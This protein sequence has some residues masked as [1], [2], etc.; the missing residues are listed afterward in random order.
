MNFTAPQNLRWSSAHLRLRASRSMIFSRAATRENNLKLQWPFAVQLKRFQLIY[1]SKNFNFKGTFRAKLHFRCPSLEAYLLANLQINYGPVSGRRFTLTVCCLKSC[2][3][4]PRSV[5]MKAPWTIVRISLG[6]V[7]L[8]EPIWSWNVEL[9]WQEQTTIRESV[10]SIMGE[11]PHKP[12]SE[13]DWR[14][15]WVL[16]EGFRGW[17]MK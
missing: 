12:S 3:I 13:H 14:G 16:P 11:R 10:T 15:W 7:V 8:S 2:R 4:H 6:E 5:T 1:A 17:L 9:Q